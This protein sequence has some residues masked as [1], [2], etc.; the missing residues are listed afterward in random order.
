MRYL[1]LLSLLAATSLNACSAAAPKPKG[2][3]SMYAITDVTVIDVKNGNALPTQTVIVVDDRIDKIGAQGKVDI[4]KGAKIINSHGLYLIPGLVDA[5]IHYFDA[6]VFGRLMIANGVLL[7]RDTGMPN[8]YILPL[9]Y[10]LNSGKTL[11]PELIATG[12]ILDGDPPIIPSISVGIKTPEDGRTE[13]RRQAAAG[14]DM[15]KTYSRLDKDVFLAIIDEA[16]KQNLKVVAHLPE[17]IYIEDAAMAGL[18]SSEHFNGFEKVIA[19]LLGEPVNLT[20]TGQAADAG[21]FQRLD[22]VN[23]QELQAVYQRIHASGMTL[24]PT[25]VTFKTL[26][27]MEP[28][29]SGNFPHSEYI[30]LGVTDLWKSMWTQQQNLPDFIWQ[31]WMRM[32]V[33]LNKAGV[34]LMIGTDLMLPGIIPGYSAH[35]E[36]M[37]WQEAGVLPAD[38]LRSATLVPAQFM[39][40]D[41]RLGS[42]SEGKSASMVLVRANPLEDIGNARQIESV[43]LRGQYFSREDLDQL[44]EEAKELAQQVITP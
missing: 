42:I 19:K 34:P 36:M 25:V 16:K 24:C 4:P 22:E 23:P 15:I 38:I 26:T 1:T 14:V 18:G 31:N 10:E 20:F 27:N 40:L 17:S 28:F 3:A 30:S 35:E 41:D 44:L 12:V 6:P 8:E 21:Y 43:F 13:V 7:V 32:V 37:I 9:R 2:F 29:W 33:D 39:D 5:H 11:G